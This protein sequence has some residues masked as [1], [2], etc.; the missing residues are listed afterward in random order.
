M[1]YSS[2]KSRFIPTSHHTFRALPPLQQLAVAW[3]E[4]RYLAHRWVDTDS[5][6]LYRMEGNFYCEVYLDSNQVCPKRVLIFT[7]M[8]CLGPY[9]DCF[10]LTNLFTI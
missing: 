1:E 9:D 3:R 10:G 5:V 2:Y 6:S 7:S 8:A 4:G